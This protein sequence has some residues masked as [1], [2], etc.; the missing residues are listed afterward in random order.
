MGRFEK[1]SPSR[2]TIAA[3]PTQKSASV[4]RS[5]RT[6]AIAA[7]TAATQSRRYARS[8]ASLLRGLVEQLGD[9]GHQPDSGRLPEVGGSGRPRDLPVKAHGRIDPKSA[10]QARRR[11]DQ[12]DRMHRSLPFARSACAKRPKPGRRPGS[13]RSRSSMA[14]TRVPAVSRSRRC[15]HVP[16]RAER[17]GEA[18][19]VRE[20]AQDPGHHARG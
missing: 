16:Q 3:C 4:P 9:R 15:D 7:T 10:K 20:V 14:E 2:A 17:G 1:T 12:K 19:H 5:R 13:A 11:D 8:Q 18:D 6:A